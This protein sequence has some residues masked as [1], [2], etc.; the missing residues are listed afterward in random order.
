MAL[1]R[2][3]VPVR[4]EEAAGSNPATQTRIPAGQN[5]HQKR[6]TLREQETGHLKE[7]KEHEGTPGKAEADFDGQKD[8]PAGCHQVRRERIVSRAGPGNSQ[9]RPSGIGTVSLAVP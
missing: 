5:P 7:Q 2:T 1:Q 3:L 6:G 4:D 8:I 9:R